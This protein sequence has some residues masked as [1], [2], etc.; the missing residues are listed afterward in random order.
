[1]AVLQ[2][3]KKIMVHDAS[4]S[5]TTPIFHSHSENVAKKG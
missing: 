4:A 1:M 3:T 5:A 2:C